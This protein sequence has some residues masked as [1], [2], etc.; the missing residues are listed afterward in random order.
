MTSQTYSHSCQLCRE[1]EG[2][3]IKRKIIVLEN[4]KTEEEEREII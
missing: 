2:V 4:L 3:V 1:R